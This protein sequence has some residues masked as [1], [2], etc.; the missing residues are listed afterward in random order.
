MA[1]GDIDDQLGSEVELNRL[2][3]QFPDFARYY[4]QIEDIPIS[5][6]F[7]IPYGAGIAELGTHVYVSS[8][9]NPVVL[10]VDCSRALAYHEATEWALRKFAGIGVDY[11]HDPAGH[12]LA[13]RAEAMCAARLLDKPLAEGWRI[14]SRYIDPQVRYDESEPV[15]DCPPDLALYPYPEE[16]RAKI[17]AAQS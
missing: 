14:Y 1:S 13:N 4:D 8:D 15:R 5:T 9:I 16:L 6:A 2:M 3:T 12:R 17:R 7:H 11:A 10:G